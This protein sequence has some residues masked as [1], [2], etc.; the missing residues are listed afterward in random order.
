MRLA[1]HRAK[2][3]AGHGQFVVLSVETRIEDPLS[4]ATDKWDRG[5]VWDWSGDAKEL[6][7]SHA[8]I[9]TDRAEVWVLPIAAAPRADAAARKVISDPAYDVYQSHFSPDGR[10]IVFE[11]T[12]NLDQAVESTLHVTPA[13]GGPWIRITDGKYWDD[14][15]RW[16]PD[17]KTIY[18]ISGR[19]GSFN[20]WGIRFDPSEGKPLGEPFRVTTFASPRL[21]IPQQLIE[22]LGISLNQNKLVLTMQDLAG[23]IWVLDNVDQ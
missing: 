23:S 3:G 6:L 21:T 2:P 8:G 1:Y 9:E 13:T 17:G 4:A 14:K 7:V 22:G 18:F 20:V 11:A 10:W 5:G 19:G 12:R 15:P 16:S